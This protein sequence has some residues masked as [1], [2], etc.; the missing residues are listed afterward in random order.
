MNSYESAGAFPFK[1]LTYYGDIVLGMFPIHLQLSITN[2]CN[3]NCPWCSCSKVDRKQELHLDVIKKIIDFFKKKGTLAVTITGGGEPTLHP[4]LPE[5]CY[6][7]CLNGI[8]IG[9]VTN[10]VSQ[11]DYQHIN[12]TVRWVRVSV[13]DYID[14]RGVSNRLPD[15]D[16]GVSMTIDKP[17]LK[18]IETICNETCDVENITHLRFVDNILNPDREGGKKVC[19]IVKRFPKAF[20]QDRSAFSRGNS[21]CLLSLIKP[22][23][24]TDGY[25]YPC[26][27]V[28]YATEEKRKFPK[29]MRMGKWFEYD[30]L[31]PFDGSICSVCYYNQYNSLLKDIC[32]GIN[33]REF[34]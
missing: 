16:I 3:K 14:L 11:K 9:L 24:G 10:G 13:T 32:K 18:L 19:N 33:H 31:K 8:E 12:K 26:C 34:V 28:Q 20:Y 17:D 23:I 7:C 6:Y 21:P 22:F 25:L 2:K 30:N 29:S 4:E 27:G 1:L 15:V 5:I